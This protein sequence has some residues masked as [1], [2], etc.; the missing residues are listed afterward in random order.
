MH[1]V[2]NHWRGDLE[3]VLGDKPYRLCLTLGALAE[4][5]S[6]L[7]DEDIIAFTERLSEGRIRATD[8]KHVFACALRGGGHEISDDEVASLMPA[9][10]LSEAI[11]IVG[12]LISLSF[13]G[14]ATGGDEAT[15]VGKP[16]P[17]APSRGR[18]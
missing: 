10:G 16:A 2:R 8:V 14:A 13:G 9:G 1:K 3:A 11:Q 17:K 5:E 7:A 15:S 4:L 18:A 6:L 12:Q